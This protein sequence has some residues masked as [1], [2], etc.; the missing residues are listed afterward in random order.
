MVEEDFSEYPLVVA[1]QHDRL[2]VRDQK[3]LGLCVGGEGNPHQHRRVPLAVLFNDP[4]WRPFAGGLGALERIEAT[5]AGYL[6]L[7]KLARAPRNPKGHALDVIDNSISRFGFINPIVV[8][9]KTGRIVSDLEG[10]VD[11]WELR[12][13][14][15]V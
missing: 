1:A 7:S 3:C 12:D 13:I 5:V 15:R 4:V 10:A 14:Y 8:N 11:G 6:P 2:V 9:E